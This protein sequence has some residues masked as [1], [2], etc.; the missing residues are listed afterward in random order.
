[1]KI[2]RLYIEVGN[3]DSNMA[4]I[5]YDNISKMGGVNS[6]NIFAGSQVIIMEYDVDA[7]T[8][9]KIKNR[10]EMLGCK[11]NK[12]LEESRVKEYEESSGL[13]RDLLIKIIISFTVFI[14]LLF[15]NY[16]GI[17]MLISL[18]LLLFVNFW[19]LWHFFDLV[20]KNRNFFSLE[21][22]VVSLS[23]LYVLYVLYVYVR[24]F[25][26]D[27]GLYIKFFFLPL[28]VFLSNLAVYIKFYMSEIKKDKIQ[29]FEKLLPLYTNIKSE[30]GIERVMSGEVKEGDILMLAKGEQLPVDGTVMSDDCY[31]DESVFWGNNS[32]VHKLKGDKV[33]ASDVVLGNCVIKAQSGVGNS[34]IYRILNLAK[35]YFNRFENDIS[36]DIEYANIK[37]YFVFVIFALSVFLLKVFS[38]NSDFH[39]VINLSYLF[40]LL[41][42]SS[43]MMSLSL[44]YLMITVHASKLGYIINNI[45]FLNKIKSV[46]LIMFNESLL[47]NR[48]VNTFNIDVKDEKYINHIYSILKLV[49][50][51]FFRYFEEKYNNLKTFSVKIQNKTGNFK[52]EGKIDNLN[53]KLNSEKKEDKDVISV[54]IEENMV[55]EIACELKEFNSIEQLRKEIDDRIKIVVVSNRKSDYSDIYR[56]LKIDYYYNIPEDEIYSVVIKYKILGY[57]VMFVGNGIWDIPSMLNADVSVAFKRG[58][59]INMVVSDSVLIRDNLKLIPELFEFE[60]R[61]RDI[62]DKNL[63]YGFVYN[64]IAVFVMFFLK[65]NYTLLVLAVISLSLLSIF[66]NSLKVY[67][68]KLMEEK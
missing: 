56:E 43:G 63:V 45:F 16:L 31:V 59:F 9:N 47:I 37:F 13:K 35:E 7:V 1:M 8:V 46:N 14:V 32:R 53:F 58:A 51:N 42:P 57:V 2:K 25:H 62:L 44:P 67:K 3:L 50:E 10:L 17:N 33:Y 22:T 11:V 49:D 40:L 26:I 6:L 60:R 12:Y 68:I 39:S 27:Y 61:V 64:I 52:F 4:E 65:V 41:I 34:I 15:S 66:L 38:E 55:A 18:F 5:V 19:G 54:L 28:Y 29:K 21:F 20:K 48:E 23:T 30:K 36:Y 24:Y